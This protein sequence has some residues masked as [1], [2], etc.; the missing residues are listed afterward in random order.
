[1][2]RFLVPSRRA[3]EP[4]SKTYTGRTE[5]VIPLEQPVLDPC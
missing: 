4:R 1:M 5:T 3:S 2:L